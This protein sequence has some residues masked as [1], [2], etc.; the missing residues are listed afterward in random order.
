[1]SH[2]FEYTIKIK[3]NRNRL[4]HGEHTFYDAGKKSSVKEIIELKDEV[5]HYL[6]DVVKNIGDYIDTKSYTKTV[7]KR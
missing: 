6:D 4:A 5:F 3:D 7:K 1:M 2:I